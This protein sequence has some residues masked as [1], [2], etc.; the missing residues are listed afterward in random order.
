MSMLFSDLRFA[1]RLLGNKPG[2][3]AAAILTLA[4]GIGANALVF[5]LID[6]VYLSDLPYRNASEL[7]DVHATQFGSGDD[8]VSIPDYLDLHAQVGAL[9]D[10]ALYTDASFNLVD[11]DAA[12]RLQGLR[13]TPSLFSTLGVGAARGRVFS[14]DE[15]APGHT[16]VA[17]LSDSLWRNRFDADPHVLDRTLRLDGEDYRIIGVMPRKFMFPRADIGLYVPFAFSPDQLGDDQRGVNYSSIVARLAPHAT[18]A[19]VMAQAAAVVRRNV[20]RS[21]A[22]DSGADSYAHWVES[23]GFGFGVRPLRDQLSGDNAQDLP[24]LQIA[25]ALVLLIALANVGNLLLTRLTARQSELAVRTALGASRRALA[26]QLF[27]EAMLL[28]AAGAVLGFGCAWLGVKLVAGS[29][30]LPAWAKFTVDY[31][32]LAFT[33]GIT[34]L[35]AIGFG[36]APALLA[37]RAHPHSVLRDAGRL[38]GGGRGARRMRATLVIVQLA[39]A[40]AL[41]AGANLLLRSFAKAAAQSPGFSSTDVLTARLTLPNSKYADGAARTRATRR[42]LDAL[43]RLPG[44]ID[45]GATTRLPF[46]GQN[47]GL[48]F[49]IAGRADD[50]SLPHAA[51]RS[52]DEGFFATLQ[53]PVLRGR[54]FAPADWDTRARNVVVDETFAQKYFPAADA[55]GQRITLGSSASGDAYTI[56]GVVGNVKHFDLTERTSRPTFYFNLAA[57]PSDSVFVAVRTRDTS[58]P[59]I[60]ALRA[61]VH[62]VDA[63]QPLFDVS[64]LEQRIHASLTGRR[65]PLQLLGLFAACALLLAAVGIYGVLAFNVEQRTGEIGLR[66]AIGADAARVRRSVLADGTRLVA[67][68]TALGM[69][70]AIAIGFGLRSRLFDVAPIDLLSLVSVAAVLIVTALAACWLPARRAARLDPLVALRH[71]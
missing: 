53:I 8:N 62:A 46:A 27:A 29:G 66:M 45:V 42:I 11:A 56:V 67:A 43:H 57:L 54:V 17:V 59:F 64:T 31:R 10:S 37:A 19:Q 35:A 61:A 40:V 5:T 9:A 7:I 14:D 49:R 13:V 63:E 68:G 1:A 50:G 6:G 55:V 24:M 58:T 39:L 21:G 22:T 36:L 47:G 23:S 30:M 12:E 60:A 34:L 16:H 25:V 70:G 65:V 28:A 52:V 4:L 18:L 33:F 38:G 51:L 3:A 32:T 48:V 15:A 26:R 69:L 2:F 71:E 20:E 41:L 44:V